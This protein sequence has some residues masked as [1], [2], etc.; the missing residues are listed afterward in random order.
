MNVHS[1][2]EAS[3]PPARVVLSS[4]GVMSAADERLLLELL[5]DC[6][7]NARVES[8]PVRRGDAGQRSVLA[9]LN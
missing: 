3:R 1:A 7:M 9:N 6:G 2:D 4:P 5:A 8:V